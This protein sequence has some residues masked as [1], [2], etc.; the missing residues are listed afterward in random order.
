L[1]A[2]SLMD[3]KRRARLALVLLQRHQD[4]IGLFSGRTSG[5]PDPDRGPGG[6]PADDDRKHQP[7]QC[8]VRCRIAEKVCHADQQVTLERRSFLGVGGE[9][10][11][12]LA[13]AHDVPDGKTPLQPPEHGGLPV[14]REIDA[15]CLVHDVTDRAKRISLV[16]VRGR[17]VRGL[18][19]LGRKV[20][21]SGHAREFERDRLGRKNH[22]RHAGR[23]GRHAGELGR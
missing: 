21:V 8:V 2:I 13:E 20:G 4:R 12:I 22:I 19:R 5:H 1:I 16:G 15:G 3:R 14:H 17:A 23:R 7:F 11:R 18:G 10:L 9:D 6:P